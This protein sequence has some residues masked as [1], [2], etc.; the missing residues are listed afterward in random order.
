MKSLVTLANLLNAADGSGK[1]PD[2]GI[3]STRPGGLARHLPARS[4]GGKANA[5]TKGLTE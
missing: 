4:P 5:V 3:K 2:M 1:G